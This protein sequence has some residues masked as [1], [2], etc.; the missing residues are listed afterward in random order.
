MAARY[1][2]SPKTNKS[3]VCNP[4]ITGVCKFGEDTPHFE[5]K[6]LADEKING[7]LKNEFGDTSTLS[8]KKKNSG[9]I[10]EDKHAEFL[11]NFMKAEKI[12]V[13]ET[14][15]STPNGRDSLLYGFVMTTKLE[16]AQFAPKGLI[17]RV[18]KQVALVDLVKLTTVATN[19]LTD[20]PMMN[21]SMLKS[22]DSLEGRPGRV[23]CIDQEGNE[24]DS[25]TYTDELEETGELQNF[26]TYLSDNNAL[27]SIT[28]NGSSNLKA[29]VQESLSALISKESGE[30]IKNMNMIV[31][32]S[33]TDSIDFK[34]K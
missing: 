13:G 19:D 18:F 8:K 2:I 1:H 27:H 3:G 11:A 17:S 15:L 4:I 24:H 33:I 28:R 12:I 16:E 14:S 5:T 30:M 20:Y 32:R 7:D 29:R 31:T 25:I 6:A 21:A 26:A 23:I 22:D 10:D 9:P 34:N